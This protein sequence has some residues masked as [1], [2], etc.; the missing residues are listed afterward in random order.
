MQALD[1]HAFAAVAAA[2]SSP[3]RDDDDDTPA[4]ITFPLI[5][6]DW[7]G[8]VASRFQENTVYVSYCGPLPY[9]ARELDE[10]FAAVGECLAAARNDRLIVESLRLEASFVDPADDYDDDGD[11]DADEGADE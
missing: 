9:R 2:L 4:S 10:L 3:L 11:D 6:P 1:P 8:A 5:R 7:G